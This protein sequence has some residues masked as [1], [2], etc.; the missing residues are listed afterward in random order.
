MME[1]L[2][3]MGR[4]DLF[5][6][7]SSA[8]RASARELYDLLQ[9][10]V[11]VFLAERS[12]GPGRWDQ[13]IPLAQRAS[14]ATVILIAHPVDEAWYVADEIVRAIGLH[15]ASP[16]DHLLVPV[17]LEPDAPLPYGLE[18]VQAIDAAAHGGLLGVAARLRDLMTWIRRNDLPLPVVP[19]MSA[20]GCDHVV[21]HERLSQLTHTQF[22]QIVLHARILR[23]LIAPVTAPLAERILDLAQLAAVAPELCR[24]VSTLLDD[25]APWT[26]PTAPPPT[27]S[28]PTG[29]P[30]GARRKAIRRA[31][32]KT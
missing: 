22:E 14:R 20:C 10:D 18:H 2:G 11:K 1:V 9:P 17:L 24:R 15:R 23:G 26:R 8:N 29:G 6:A 16:E 19:A 12:L 28:P 27:P 31:R 30:G 13:Q 4:P 5:L 25:R 21:L 7:S 32:R 3:G